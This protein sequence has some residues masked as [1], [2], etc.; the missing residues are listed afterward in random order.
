MYCFLQIIT[1]IT[2]ALC[3][4]YTLMIACFAYGWLRTESFQKK[5]NATTRL[6]V[7][8]AARNEEMMIGKCLDALIVQAYDHSLFEIIVADDHSSDA[9]AAIVQ[10]YAGR[11]ENI[12]LIR[13]SDPKE[14]GKKKAIAAAIAQTQAELIVTTDADCT[15]G[16]NWLSS[17]AAFYEE[18][19]CKMIVGPVA[20]APVETL[21]EKVQSLELMAL[22]G[23]TAGSLFYHK[24]TLCN[25]ANLAYTREVFHELNGFSGIDEKASGDDVLLMYKLGK[26]YPESIAFL[27]D[28]DAIVTTP[29]KKRFS[30]FISQRK[31][32]AS[33]GLGALNG[34]SKAVALLVYGCSFSILLMGLI[35][36]F[37][38]LRSGIYLP[39][40]KIGLILFAIKCIIDILLLFLAAFFF[41]RLRDLFYFL[42][43]QLIYIVYVVVVGMQG[44]RGKYEWKGRKF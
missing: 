40:F 16:N 10:Q 20:F 30:E 14:S 17:I 3:A 36:G 32:W 44:N 25:G 19:R 26:K 8:I 41:R 4:L 2:A 12:K 5:N 15:M 11:Y 33:K 29:A 6:A 31:R 13:L 21:F 23:S 22:M 37:A 42:P 24:A 28:R 39:F 7:I 35:S 18:K 34:P 9:T 38:S 43:L 27:K 1:I